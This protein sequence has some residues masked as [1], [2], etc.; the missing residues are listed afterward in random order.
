MHLSKLTVILLAVAALVF[1]GFY[2]S[3]GKRASRAYKSMLNRGDMNLP[4]I[5]AY[6]KTREV[7]GPPYY[8]AL[9]LA[10]I[11]DDNYLEKVVELYAAAQILLQTG[12]AERILA[13]L[14][15]ESITVNTAAGRLMAD[16]Y[17]GYENPQQAMRLLEYSALRKDQ[18]AAL[19][20]SE[21]FRRFNC[22]I[23]TANWARIANERD[24]IAECAM[25]TIE[26]TSLDE[27]DWQKVLDNESRLKSAWKTGAVP[28]LE[29]SADCALS[30]R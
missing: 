6:I 29:Y 28:T 27:N 2:F 8:Q 30:R 19:Y 24:D 12:T 7:P 23:G 5:D 25:I 10:A 21:L 26:T 14:P 3:E 22:P 11:L 1:S 18:D 15:S 13:L 20:L 9:N 4:V 17:Y 16:A